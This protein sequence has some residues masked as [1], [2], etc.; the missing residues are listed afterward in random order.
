M[1]PPILYT[2]SVAAHGLVV[3]W[4][5][6]FRPGAK[7]LLDRLGD[8][9]HEQ[10]S[11]QYSSEFK[12][13]VSLAALDAPGPI[14]AGGVVALSWIRMETLKEGVISLNDSG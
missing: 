12:A 5:P 13:K 4:S 8:P 10:E 2:L 6:K 9:D 11:R 14:I 1:A 3:K 7:L